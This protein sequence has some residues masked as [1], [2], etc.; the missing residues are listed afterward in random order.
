[1]GD[2][3]VT[4][5]IPTLNEAETIARVVAV[6]L[7]SP[8]VME[9]LVV[10]DKSV[11]STV[12]NAREAGANVITS[13]KLG[14]GASMRDG[15]LVAKGEVLVYLDGDIVDYSDDIVE[16]LVEPILAGRADFAKSC[17]IRQAGR[18]TELV[19][20]PLLSLL[21]PD[22]LHIKQPLSGMIA[23]KKT[24]LA[25]SSFEDDYGVDIG[26]LIDMHLR[27]ARIEQVDIHHV[28]NRMKPWPELSKMSRE[29]ARAILRRASASHYLHL[30]DMQ[31]INVIRD[32]MEFAINE[33]LL[34]LQK[35]A[36]FDMDNTI[37]RG[38]FMETAARTLG[39]EKELIEI[40]AA[41]HES[42]LRTK[43]IARLLKGRHIGELIEV[44]DT[45]TLT[46]FAAEIVAAMKGRGYIVGII[47]DSYDF[48]ANHVKT[49]IGADFALANELEF[50]QS[51]ATGEVK[52]PSFFARSA[53]SICN[54]SACKTHALVDIAAR[55]GV[56][57]ADIVAVGDGEPDVCMIKHAGI[58]VSFC[59]RNELLN[60]V[61]DFRIT[62]PSFKGLL[63]VA[64]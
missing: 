60:A 14:K 23:A 54:H 52:I 20:R 18:V 13:T 37:L 4:V 51:V 9:V 25:S 62:E 49:K 8:S 35:L 64:Q 48:A 32:Q 34:T 3:L 44:L 43:L 11:D 6:A 57:L 39:L 5:V 30:E 19:A 21:F 33:S 56:G 17:F 29:V 15:L 38:R 1:M 61:A 53:A 41:N 63:E 55:Y 2:K 7:R 22:L 50:S 28:S 10:D 40:L 42:W 26:L 36:V 16:R 45:I 58:G 27:R 12:V 47:S 31:T 24:L 59:S 46:H